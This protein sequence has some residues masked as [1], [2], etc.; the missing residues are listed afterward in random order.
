MALLVFDDGLADTAA[1]RPVRR[2]AYRAFPALRT[3]VSVKERAWQQTTGWFC[4]PRGY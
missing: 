4:Y 1:M 2:D 3:H